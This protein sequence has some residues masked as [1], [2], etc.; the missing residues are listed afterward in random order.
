MTDW[1]QFTVE[2]RLCFSYAEPGAQCIA[3]QPVDAQ[4]IKTLDSQVKRMAQETGAPFALA[5]FQVTDW[6]RELSP[7]EAPP[8]FGKDRFGS[9]A[10]ATLQWLESR[11]LPDLFGRF[12]LPENTPVILGGYSLAAFFSL[13][14]AYQTDRFAAVAAASPSVWFPGWIEYAQAHSPLT[15]CVYLSLGDREERTKNKTMARVGD[16]LRRQYDLLAGRNRVL[17]WHEGNHFR[18]T[19][20]R[21]ARAFIWCVHQICGAGESRS[22]ST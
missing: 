21:C 2:G 22:V 8:V 1:E 5:A 18:D 3:V 13:W 15:D 10:S 7:W 6:N 20:L 16:C 14:S 4:D 9:G 12:R 17:V 19:D 11:L